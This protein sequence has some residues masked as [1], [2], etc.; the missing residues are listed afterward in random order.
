VTQKKK[1]KGQA[2]S[3]REYIASQKDTWRTYVWLWKE[4]TTKESRKHLF[5]MLSWLSI[6]AVLQAFAP[7]AVRY[8]FMGLDERNGYL[9]VSGILAAFLFSSVIKSL[10][11][12]HDSAREDVMALNRVKLED[13]IKRLF[14]EKSVAQHIHESKRL[15]ASTIEK[16]KWKMIELQNI[17]LF[18]M[19]PLTLTTVMSIAALLAKDLVSGGIMIANTL[20]YLV[21]SLYLN[22][23]VSKVTTPID[24]DFRNVNRRVSER[25]EQQ[26][27]V[28]TCGHEE[29]ETRETTE[30]LAEVVSRDRNFW[31]WYI[32]ASTLR[33]YVNNACFTAVMAW[34]AWLVWTG[35]WAD[36]G[37]LYPLYSWASRI[38][39][40]LWRFGDNELQM[41]KNVPSVRSTIEALQIAPEIVDSPDATVLDHR[42]P[43]RIVFEK[44]SHTYPV[45]KGAVAEAS[46]TLRD[47][48]LVVEAGETVAVMGPSGA[49]KT[50]VMKLL[51]RFCDPTSGRIS[52]GGRDLRSITQSS[53]KRGIGY[54]PQQAAV[55]D[56]TIRDNLVY[57]LAEEERKSVSDEHLLEITRLLKIDFKSLDTVV[58][59]NG[60]KLSGGQAQRLMLGAAVAKNPWLLVIDE[61]T[62]SLDSLTEKEV[63]AG[64][65]EALSGNT[66]ALIVTHRL[67]TVRS[68]C[69]KFVVLRPASEVGPDESQI[70]AVASSFEELYPI[71]PTFRRLADAQGVAVDVQ[72]IAVA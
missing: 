42:V 55:L 60:L 52:V 51:L 44:A 29:L 8:V 64:L 63:Q 43:H 25:M 49:G 57:G 24:E 59:R 48:D 46:P 2:T 36:V 41:S 67:N 58:G 26:E 12:R 39:E 69:D 13:T 23:Q 45:E 6:S 61:G 50:T 28:K 11:K 16:G 56:G 27:R 53:Y 15:S 32:D 19:F 68:L 65:T 47:I 38:S 31:I 34:G 1:L 66:S 40:N 33:A 35:K 21:C 20:V 14:F 72:G 37:V 71:S 7:E 9:V 10:E 62:A 30:V 4:A 18:G 70:E 17:M 5:I 3:F 22:Y 54:A